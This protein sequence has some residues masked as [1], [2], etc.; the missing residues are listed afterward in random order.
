MKKIAFGILAAA[1]SVPAH[2]ASAVCRGNPD[3]V[4]CEAF[5]A[6]LAAET[7]TQ[8]AERIQRLEKNR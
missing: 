6:K 8:K 5:E 1:M 3:P 7:P 4:A 2:A